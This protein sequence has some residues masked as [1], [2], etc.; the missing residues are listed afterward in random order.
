MKKLITIPCLA[1]LLTISAVFII[2]DGVSAESPECNV[3]ESQIV[4]R[5]LGY[6]PG[7]LDG[8]WGQKTVNAT[9]RFQKAKKLPETG[10]L[11]EITCKALGIKVVRPE[12]KE[13]AF[14]KEGLIAWGKLVDKHNVKERKLDNKVVMKIVKNDPSWGSGY[15]VSG[16][17]NSSLKLVLGSDSPI[18]TKSGTLK[19][20]KFSGPIE[21]SA[22]DSEFYSVLGIG[23]SVDL[24]NQWIKIFGIKI[25]SG[26]ILIQKS[27]I[28]YIQSEIGQ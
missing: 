12:L 5:S 28:K 24:P 27:G 14:D 3:E 9:M 6:D 26:C 4:L 1:I 15:V 16:R 8:L 11:D 13:V 20:R 23:T 10:R 17:N 21:N 18:S 25:K 2:S 22:P 19:V 7:P